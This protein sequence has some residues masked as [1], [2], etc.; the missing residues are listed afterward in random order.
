MIFYQM[1]LFIQLKKNLKPIVFKGF[2]FYENTILPKVTMAT[3]A[4]FRK[5]LENYLEKYY[6]KTSATFPNSYW[7][8]YS[9]INDFGKFN[10]LKNSAKVIN[11]QL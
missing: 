10:M 4:K 8:Y 1:E 5:F 9:D 3:K 7:S 11:R 2:N 6:F